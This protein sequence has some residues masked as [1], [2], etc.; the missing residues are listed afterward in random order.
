M[1]RFMH[2]YYQEQ[3]DTKM[4]QLFVGYLQIINMNFNILLANKLFIRFSE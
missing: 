3:T 1:K 4:V 2:T